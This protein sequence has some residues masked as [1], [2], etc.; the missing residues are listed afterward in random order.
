MEVTFY[1]PEN[2]E[3]LME[4]YKKGEQFLLHDITDSAQSLAR[5]IK[6]DPESI[7][8]VWQDQML[9]GTISFMEDGRMA[10]LLRIMIDPV[11][12]AKDVLVKKLFDT[13]EGIL[14]KRGYEEIHSIA[15]LDHMQSD[16]WRAQN[17]FARSRDYSWYFKKV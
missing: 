3:Q 14:K 10:L 5:K 2:Y 8:L 6:R 12:N 17:G 9:A 1:K 7:I 11:L 15:R 13:A 4:L 16:V